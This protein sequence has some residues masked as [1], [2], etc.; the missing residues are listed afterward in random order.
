[1]QH[2]AKEAELF[3]G[4]SDGLH[5]GWVRRFTVGLG[6]DE[7]TFTAMPGFGLPEE[8][9]QDRR[10]IYPFVGVEWLEDRFEKT[11]NADN[12]ERVED[13]HLGA[14]IYSQLGYA[15][16]ALGSGTDAWLFELGAARGFRP[17]DGDTLLLHSTFESRWVADGRNHY[18]LEAG[19]RYYHRQSERRLLYAELTGVTGQQFDSNQL[20]T[21]G[22][23]TGL[24][25]YPIRYQTGDSQVLL[26]LEQ[27][28]FTDWYPFRLFRV[29]G[30]AFFDAGRVWGG[31]AETGNLGLLR[32][33]GLGLRIASPRS[34]TGRM[35]HIDVAWPLDG[36]PDIR[37]PQFILETSRSF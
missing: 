4:W 12:I 29:G 10:D 21:L 5:G 28:I 32:D 36:P 6:Y 23:D 1:L 9:P 15:S 3:Y 19:A 30:A 2:V 35:L 26:T 14:R 8:A 11:R 16:E 18:A 22:G 17:R 33:V 13:R 37:G 20:P 7:H 25:G 24:R 27:R 31:G 34:S